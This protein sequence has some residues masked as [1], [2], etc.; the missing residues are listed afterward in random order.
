MVF[1]GLVTAITTLAPLFVSGGAAATVLGGALAI[2]TGPIGI[3]VAAVVGLI[4]IWV[5]WG[6]D[7]KAIVASVFNTAKSWLVDKWEGSIFQS[8]ARLIESMT[9]LWVALHVKLVEIFMKIG[10][11]AV[12]WLVEKMKP[13]YDFIKPFIDKII[14]VWVAAYTK[15]TEV[16]TQLYTAV[17][18][19]LVDKF[20]A[21]VDSIKAKIDAVTG[22]FEDMYQKVVGGSYVPDM[23]NG[24]AAQFARLTRVMV[25]PTESATQQTTDSFKK[26]SQEWQESLNKLMTGLSQLAQVA[27]ESMSSVVRSI[28]T[29]VGSLK[30]GVDGLKSF[31]DGMTNWK[32]GSTW[33]GI[34]GM[35]A[36]ILGM[37]SAAISAGKAIADLFNR[38]KG[39]DMVEK[40]A[41]SFGGFDKLHALLN[42]LGDEGERLWI[43]LTQGVGR[44]NKDQAAAAIEEVRR[45]LEKILQ[46]A[47]QIPREIDIDV[48]IRKSEVT[49]DIE[50]VEEAASFARGSGGIRDFGR[51]TLAMLHG[52]EGVYTEAQVR[53]MRGS[54]SDGQ[55]AALKSEVAGMRRDFKNLPEVLALQLAT[56]R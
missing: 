56:V 9:K 24:I 20:T 3:V 21:I 46:T 27:G 54:G 50:E 44:N 52:R 35:T 23:V 5:K 33:E 45:A 29:V 18:T 8:V 16:V 17:K 1:G 4:A 13:V 34:V 31:K 6:D 36:G 43:L 39:R 30:A 25:A 12:L 40:F 41:E 42:Q 48:T 37:V 2:L 10:G 47:S 7:I 11:A 26:A 55:W 22:F 15:V 53:Q 19:W 32:N 51:G 28:S 49:E 14:G 38:D